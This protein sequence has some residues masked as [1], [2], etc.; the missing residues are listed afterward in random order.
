MFSFRNDSI[1]EEIIFKRLFDIEYEMYKDK[2]NRIEEYI[3]NHGFKLE[4]RDKEKAIKELNPNAENF[5]SCKKIGELTRVYFNEHQV[6]C[7][8]C[9][10]FLLQDCNERK[11]IAEK[12]KFYCYI[13]PIIE[14]NEIVDFNE[15]VLCSKEVVENIHNY[16][17]SICF[18]P[19]GYM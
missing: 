8:L 4:D 14:E 7:L 2:V 11:M 3:R 19:E 15:E 9:D 10:C 5:V 17:D 18:Y 12:D 1:S 13:T 16:M 6:Q